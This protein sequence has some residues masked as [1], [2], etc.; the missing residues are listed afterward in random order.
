MKKPFL[1]GFKGKAHR[2]LNRIVFCFFIFAVVYEKIGHLEWSINI[3]KSLPIWLKCLIL[4]VMLASI[5]FTT[6]RIHK[7]AFENIFPRLHKGWFA[8]DG[9]ILIAF[10]IVS[11]DNLIF[12]H[13]GTITVILLIFGI[14]RYYS[15]KASKQK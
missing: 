13:S 11:A 10:A 9:I 15:H 7:R 8:W 2:R 4:I 6:W 14:G 5:S 1:H 12:F 3:A